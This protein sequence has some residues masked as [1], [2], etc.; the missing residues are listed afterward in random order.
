MKI[1][2]S[3]SIL[4]ALLMIASAFMAVADENNSYGGMIVTEDGCNGVVSTDDAS[5]PFG[6]V[7]KEVFNG[8]DWVDSI[9]AEKGQ[10]LNFRLYFE[11][12]W[13]N[14]TNAW[15][16]DN[17]N[18]TDILP[19]CLDYQ[20][21]SANY[22]PTDTTGDVL[23][24]DSP[25]S[26][27]VYNYSHS[28]NPHDIIIIT[29]NAT[30][31]DCTGPNG[32]Q[33]FVEISAVE[34]CS[35]RKLYQNDTATIIVPCECGELN[36]TKKVWNETACAWE[37]T[38][39][40]EI[41]E[42][43]VFNITVTYNALS[44]CGDHL[45]DIV[46]VDNYD[47]IGDDL[48]YIID[49]FTYAPSEMGPSIVWNL[50]ADHGVV[51]NDGQSVSIEFTVTPT[52]INGTSSE[53]KNYVTVTGHEHCCDCILEDSDYANFTVEQPCEPGIEVTKK[54]WNGTAW[55]DL[56]DNLVLNQDV[57]FKIEVA[58]H[59]CDDYKIL[60]MVVKD[61]LPCCLEYLQTTSIESTGTIHDDPTIEVS[62]DGKTIFWNWTYAE[63]LELVDGD[64]LTIEFEANVTNYC[65]DIDQN[66]AY[67]EAW[68]CSGPTFYGEDDVDVN[69]TPP[70]PR[71]IKGAKLPN[72]PWQ[73]DSI[74]VKKGNTVTFQMAL[75]YFGEENLND[76]QFV[77]EMPC[78]LEYIGNAH[79]FLNSDSNDITDEFTIEVSADNKTVWFNSTG[80]LIIEDGQT[81]AV[82][83][84]AEVTG[85]TGTCEECGDVVNYG[86][87]KGLV[88]CPGE[89]FFMDDDITIISGCP[90]C[91]PSIPQIR[92][93]TAGLTGQELTF[94]FKTEDPNGDQVYYMID[95]GGNITSWIGPSNSGDEISQ[96]YTFNEPGTY[97]IK[98][99]AKNVND[100]E[101][102]WTP[103]GYEHAVV[104]TNESGPDEK[105]L[106]VTVSA[107]S[108]GRIVFTVE[109]TGDVGMENINWTVNVTGGLLG[110]YEY[111]TNC[112]IDSLEAGKN[113]TETTGY[114]VG[115]SSIPRGFGKVTV[116][117]NLNDGD[118][119][120]DFEFQGWL[121]G[122]IFL[123]LG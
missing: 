60:N 32:E 1:K 101:S 99:K 104:I 79:V 62:S 55:T 4:M 76:I 20:E 28:G 80:S 115:P 17:I 10:V 122:K 100:K 39:Q 75:Y 67:V 61:D 84:D 53:F 23:Y 63:L 92:G 114:P 91:P 86:Y 112:T 43:V 102:S 81:V 89:S 87:V 73:F 121:L 19:S 64:T 110:R 24:W 70:V 59:A 35:G 25:V 27:P 111:E 51:L 83:F 15:D 96:T 37:D 77:D 113:T 54:V 30:V 56:V 9:E 103:T 22:E 116:K 66:W 40:A 49:G 88:G 68:G 108:F 71:F 34:H 21:G 107:F 3:I 82:R 41:G 14:D 13:T 52:A 31:A 85:V 38:Y 36:V 95:F 44:Q 120:K 48:S 109:N 8:T 123:M 12:R 78:I 106:N 46:V 105:E 29:Y 47:I 74:D 119:N 45:N 5:Y 7:K 16:C 42:P 90:D 50:T 117:I 118:Y 18:I 58:Y 94:Y 6:I 57:K 33:N 93:P 69:C 26:E 11:Y 65:E 97:L 2:V 72:E 98:A